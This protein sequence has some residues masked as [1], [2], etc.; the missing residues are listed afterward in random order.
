MVSNLTLTPGNILLPR[1]TELG[2]SS[3]VCSRDV[4]KLTES[5]VDGKGLKERTPPVSSTSFRQ[6]VKDF[7][8]PKTEFMV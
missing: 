5:K 3:K 2:K 6:S 1:E 7:C 8:F 4:R